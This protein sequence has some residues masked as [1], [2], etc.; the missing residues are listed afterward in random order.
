MPS[1]V[2]RKNQELAA[3]KMPELKTNVENI[4]SY[5]VVFLGYPI[6]AM[7]VPPPVRSFIERNDLTGKMIVPFCTHDGYGPGNSVDIIK[8]LLPGNTAVLDTFDIRGSRADSA[9]QPV[10]SWL[11][12]IVKQF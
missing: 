12:R 2:N 5:D 3:G 11:R 10:A 4:A 6:W 8:K 1:L 7:T 9:E